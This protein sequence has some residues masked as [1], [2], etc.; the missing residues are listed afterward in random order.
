MNTLSEQITEYLKQYPVDETLLPQLTQQVLQQVNLR[1]IQEHY[2]SPL[3]VAIE[4]A[5]KVVT[6]WLITENHLPATTE[7]I[8]LAHLGH[9]SIDGVEPSLR[10]GP[11]L[12]EL[13]M[14]TQK[15]EFWSLWRGLIMLLHFILNKMSQ[16]LRFI[17]T[18]FHGRL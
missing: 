6:T 3:E 10:N 11:P 1:L 4:E 9:L 18:L 8:L 12:A 15:I 7:Q 16:L 17:S 14:P 13:L 2:E 5:Q